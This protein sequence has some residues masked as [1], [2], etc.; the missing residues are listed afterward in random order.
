[1]NKHHTVEESEEIIHHKMH[2]VQEQM[3]HLDQFNHYI[4]QTLDGF[5]YRY[6]ESPSKARALSNEVMRV[7]A[8]EAGI[9]EAIKIKNPDLRKGIG[10][11]VKRVSREEGPTI[12]RELRVHILSRVPGHGG[13]CHVM[14]R[15]S[16]G[17][18][19]HNFEKGTYVEKM[20]VLHFE[21]DIHFR[22]NLAKHLET[23]CE[24]FET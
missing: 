21:D 6:F 19:E 17:H 10:E 22:N 15:V 2:E 12:A 24:L 7:M 18:P 13:N 8:I 23:V 14:A 4:L 3:G 20:S 1:M 16:F 11:L 9:K 5:A